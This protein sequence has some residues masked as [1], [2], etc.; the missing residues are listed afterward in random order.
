V[1]KYDL[2]RRRIAPVAF[3]LAIVLMARDACNKQQ[4]GRATFTL[5]LGAARAD[6]RAV[7][8]EVWLGTQEAA[9]YYR[10]APLGDLRFEVPLPANDGEVRVDIDRDGKRDHVVR[11]VHADDG[12]TVTVMLGDALK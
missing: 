5:D 10:A 2:F 3:G 8:A 9:T 6:V 7:T 1:T 12:A 4:Q 11:H